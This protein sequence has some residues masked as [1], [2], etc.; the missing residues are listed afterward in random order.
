MTTVYSSILTL[1]STPTLERIWFFV[2]LFTIFRTYC[3]LT[4]SQ[5]CTTYIHI[6]FRLCN[7]SQCWQPGWCAISGPYCHK[8][9]RTWAKRS[10]SKNCWAILHYGKTRLKR[11]VYHRQNRPTDANIRV[12]SNTPARNISIS[13]NLRFRMPIIMLSLIIIIF[14]TK[15]N[16]TNRLR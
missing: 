1:P 15:T 9:G 5:N 11:L 3:Q 8:G 16:L 13:H 4:L 2:V 6:L 12:T 14:L 10:W 7:T